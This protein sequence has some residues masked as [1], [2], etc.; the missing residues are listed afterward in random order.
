VAP[1][2]QVFFI[3]MAIKPLVS[4]IIAGMSIALIISRFQREFVAMLEVLK[5]ALKLLT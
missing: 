1:Q 4:V 5:H 2:L 3:A